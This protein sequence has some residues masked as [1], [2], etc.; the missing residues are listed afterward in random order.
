MH[1]NQVLKVKCIG[2]WCECVNGKIVK[3]NESE[4][5]IRDWNR[6][7][8][9]FVQAQEFCARGFPVSGA[10]SNMFWHI[11]MGRGAER[12][13]T[14]RSRKILKHV[15]KTP[16]PMSAKYWL[17]IHSPYSFI[18]INPLPTPLYVYIFSSC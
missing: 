3:S 17:A 2:V 10:V 15:Q 18:Y 13:R 8:F 12:Q 6:S 16:D 14:S 11:G 1:D 5:G 7:F 4:L 9:I